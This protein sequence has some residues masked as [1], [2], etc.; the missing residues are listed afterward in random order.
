MISAKKSIGL[1]DRRFISPNAKIGLRRL[2][3]IAGYSEDTRYRFRLY[4]KAERVRSYVLNTAWFAISHAG[5][6]VWKD[7]VIFRWI[8]SEL[9]SNRLAGQKSLYSRPGRSGL[10]G[11][12]ATNS[13]IIKVSTAYL[14]ELI[15]SLV[16]ITRF[17]RPYL[18]IYDDIR[19]RKMPCVENLD[20]EDE[21]SGFSTSWKID[22][23]DTWTFR[24]YFRV[25]PRSLLV[26][27]FIELSF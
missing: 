23:H 24:I 20:L 14:S 3:E 2:F 15:C 18:R 6:T 8:G 16:S 4:T 12:E 5:N 1:S 11:K 10:A 9:I 13:N 22:E 19:S 27:H 21:E 25:N 26:R 7:H 17:V